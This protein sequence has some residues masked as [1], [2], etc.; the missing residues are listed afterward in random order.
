MKCQSF[1]GDFCPI[2][3]PLFHGT[4]GTLVLMSASMTNSFQMKGE[5]VCANSRGDARRT[6]DFGEAKK[7]T[8]TNGVCRRTLFAQ[9]E[10]IVM[11]CTKASC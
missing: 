8:L 4:S 9:R 1:S 11:A 6:A 10:Q 3:L 7:R 2:S 5:S